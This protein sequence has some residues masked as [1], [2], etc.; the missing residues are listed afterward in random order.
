[1]S[2]SPHTLAARAG[3]RRSVAAGLSGI[4]LA[5]A[6]TSAVATD[7]EFNPW[8]DLGGGYND[9]VLL[10]P[11]G[12]N[13]VG[14][15]DAIA[16]ARVQMLAQG[17]NWEWLAT[18]EARGTWYPDYSNFDSNGEFL[19]LNAQRS[20]PRYTLGLGAYGSSQSLI[21]GYLPTTAV[22][23][24]LGQTE[25]GTTLVA[26]ANNMRQNLG[27]LTPTYTLQMTPR[28]SLQLNGDYTDSSFSRSLPAYVGYKNATGSAGL[29]LAESSLN[30]IILRAT[31]ADFRPGSGRTADTY[32]AE[33]EWDGKY[34]EIKQ[35]YLRIGAEHTE[36]S[37]AVASVA[38]APLVSPL[39][40]GTTNWSAGAGT[41][42]IYS[43]TE[44]FVDATRNVAPTPQG[45]A[46][47]LNQLRLRLAER[48]TPRFAA[49][50]G[51]RAIYESPLN[52]AVPAVPIVHAQHYNYA[53]TGF[54][55]RLQ[56]QFS[57]I[58]EYSFTE[59]HFNT[60]PG[61]ANSIQLSFV[62]EPH[63]PAE[64]PAITVAY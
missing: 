6:V 26:P 50:V 35:Y 58:A 15:A 32:G 42:W 25:P 38:G 27:S 16:D 56:R 41:H 49:F 30:S 1:V 20:S 12:V 51:A 23:T 3:L 37:G 11:S 59:Y 9:N 10:A 22:G 52:G 28:S 43:L 8:V 46:V 40:S 2:S 17:P 61:E 63:R 33:A 55:W 54:E 44:I 64:G 14:A 31:G 4:C 39:A 13:K 48:L 5:L 45:Y 19:T 18:P 47:N 60:P 7:Y 24:G 57:V 62:Y 53:T 21:T 34:S 29:V 36:F